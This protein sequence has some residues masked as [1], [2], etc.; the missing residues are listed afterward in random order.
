MTDRERKLA[1]IVGA[2]LVFGVIYWGYNKYNDAVKMRTNQI[3]SLET[4]KVQIEE[5]L[6]SGAVAESQMYE[7][8]IR[9]LPGNKERARSKYSK[10]LL[11][12]V[13]ANKLKG[14]N[15]DPS[16]SLS[17]AGLYQKHTFRVT[18]NSDVPNI[19]NL[20]H[21]FYAKDYLHRIRILDLKPA[22]SGGF[23][24]ELTVDA[25]GLNNVPV[26]AAEPGT[27]SW[28]V[29]SDVAAYRE[30]ILN[31]NLFEPPN[32]SPKYTGRSTLEAVI[33]K[34]TSLPLTFQDPE[35]HRISYELVSGPEDLV[36]L[37]RRGGT[38]RVKSDE[39][40]D[41]EVVVRATDS[42]YPNRTV[43]KKLL[44]KIVDPPKEPEP[45][46]EKPKFDD[47]SQTFL[48]GLVQRGGN[49]TAWM[50]VRTRDKTQKLQL[51][52]EFE[53]GTVKG[54]VTKITAKF[55]EIEID[56]ARVTLT[57]RANLRDAAARAKED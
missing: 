29:D 50:D 43:E 53:I 17:V 39:K 37:D 45:P 16:T 11:D 2:L 4:Q 30:P 20:L 33:G 3:A 22:R 44:V 35:K 48:T 21:S 8:F 31:R 27:K 52:D 38:L 12:M 46:K 25:I 9:S 10:W 34:S 24:V 56:G 51:G 36:R 14:A 18:G 26:D 15:V 54:K 41:I 57:A 13:Q 47:A 19:L 42:G 23:D 32:K 40:K 5:Q 7:Y 28:R 6:Y 49:W 1:L 55:V